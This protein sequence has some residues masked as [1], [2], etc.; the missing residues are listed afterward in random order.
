MKVISYIY[1]R[2]VQCNVQLL[3]GGRYN[4]RMAVSRVNLDVLW[5]GI[6]DL[7]RSY[8]PGCTVCVAVE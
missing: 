2:L 7:F 3:I 1:R 8:S 4:Q 6:G 5:K